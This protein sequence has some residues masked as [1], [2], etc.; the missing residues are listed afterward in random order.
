[1]TVLLMQAEETFRARAVNSR[2]TS[3]PVRRSVNFGCSGRIACHAPPAER[4]GGDLP[5]PAESRWL[6]LAEDA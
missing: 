3:S 2:S 5:R 1:M 4:P 6:E